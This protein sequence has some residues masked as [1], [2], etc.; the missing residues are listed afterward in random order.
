MDGPHSHW[1]IAIV[2]GNGNKPF[3]ENVAHQLGTRLTDAVVD[4]FDDGEVHVEITENI[5]G[6]D[7]FV[8]NPTQPPAENFFELAFIGNAAYSSAGRVTG[9]I[10]YFG[11]QCQERKP[12]P[13]TPES[14]KLVAGWLSDSGFHRIVLFEPHA[15]AMAGFFHGVRVEIAYATPVVIEHLIDVLGLTAEN[16]RDFVV[17]SADMGG[18]RKVEAY[19][20]RLNALGFK[21]IGFGGALKLGTSSDGSVR[22]LPIGDFK[23]RHVL[24]ID[25]MIRTG[26]TAMAHARAVKGLGAKS[27]TLIGFHPVFTSIEKCR[28]LAGCDAIDS[29]IVTSSLPISEEKRQAL[30]VK[31]IVLPVELL[32]SKLVRRLHFDESMSA[33]GEYPEYIADRP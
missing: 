17:A 3:V 8:I 18:G 11:Y 27:Y 6:N 4:R 33:L 21:D 24:T 16:A 26:T 2:S 22:I 15:D 7:V 20:R 25:D 29:I 9:I 32:F 1:K 23:D 12:R 28:A 5:R 13:R 30:G 10:P 19:F 14:A 31:L